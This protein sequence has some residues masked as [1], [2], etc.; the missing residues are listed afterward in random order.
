MLSVEGGSFMSAGHAL[1]V[2]AY[3]SGAV[4]AQDSIFSACVRA[5]ACGQ[6][7]L[8]TTDPYLQHRLATRVLQG[9]SWRSLLHC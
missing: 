4:L 7:S 8:T 1:Y 6:A 3:S 5:R 9:G 2:H